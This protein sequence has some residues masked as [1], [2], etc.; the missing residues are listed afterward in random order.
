MLLK[1]KKK[2]KFLP[3]VT[4]RTDFEAIMLS[5]VRQTEKDKCDLVYT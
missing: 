1:F 4:T 5:E 2:N 3:C